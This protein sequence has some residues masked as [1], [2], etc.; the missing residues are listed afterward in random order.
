MKTVFAR[1]WRRAL[2]T[3]TKL[4]NR[5]PRLARIA[6]RR[7]HGARV[8]FYGTFVHGGDLVFDVGANVGNRT[9]VFADLGA[10]VVAIEPQATCVEVLRREFGASPQVTIVPAGLAAEPGSQQLYTSSASTLTSM[11]PE[12]IEATRSSGRFAEFSFEEGDVVPT[13]TLDALIAEHGTPS[14][15]KIDVEGFEEQVL[16]G[17]SAPIPLVSFEFVAERMDATVRVLDR[18]EA[19]GDYRYNLVVGEDYAF[20]LPEWR[21]RAELMSHLDSLDDS[22]VFGDLF[23]RHAG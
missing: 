15:C 1:S 11:S 3:A 9:A 4:V 17:L 6:R 22:M 18:L 21:S 23:A 2:N 8:T 16:A 13:T 7:G 14:F 19:L 12:F 5:S 20:K 10:R